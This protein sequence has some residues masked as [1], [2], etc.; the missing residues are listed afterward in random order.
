MPVPNQADKRRRSVT[1]VT[2][3]PFCN[4][5][6][7]TPSNKSGKTP[8]FYNFGNCRCFCT[9]YICI[10]SLSQIQQLQQL[11][12]EELQP[13]TKKHEAQAEEHNFEPPAKRQHVEPKN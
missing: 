12:Q 13:A 2:E 6:Y 10:L 1:V 9:C 4:R 3:V 7:R 5:S 8:I 11:Q